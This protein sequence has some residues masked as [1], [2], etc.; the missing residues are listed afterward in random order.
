MLFFFVL[1]KV[2]FNLCQ[3]KSFLSYEILDPKIALN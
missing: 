3:A 2:V 1:V